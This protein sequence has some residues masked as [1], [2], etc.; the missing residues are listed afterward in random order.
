MRTVIMK[1]NV[2]AF[3]EL[4]GDARQK[5]IDDR[6]FLYL[7][8]GLHEDLLRELGNALDGDAREPFEMN[9]VLE[10]G[11]S[12]DRKGLGNIP[13]VRKLLDGKLNGLEAAI[14]GKLIKAGCDFYSEHTQS[15]AKGTAE[16]VLIDYGSVEDVSY[17]QDKAMEKARKIVGE[18]YA[19]VCES[20][21]EKALM[22]EN[23]DG[24]F[25]RLIAQDGKEY[26]S[27]GEIFIG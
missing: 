17:F 14:V 20:L 27:D 11:F 15:C 9:Y 13:A 25:A 26:T 7:E 12:F 16:D 21:F 2:Y 3:E 18:W 5:A 8:N 1:A 4:N 6:R 24:W 19:G 22:L 10:S 23:D